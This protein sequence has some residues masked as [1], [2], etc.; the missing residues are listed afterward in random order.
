[1]VCS[2]PNLQVLT[3]S[4]HWNGYI[5][6]LWNMRSNKESVFPKVTPQ[7]S[8]SCWARTHVSASPSPYN[9]LSASSNK[10]VH[11]SFWRG[12][13]VCVHMSVCIYLAAGMQICVSSVLCM[14]MCLCVCI[15]V[16]IYACT[17]FLHVYNL[18]TQLSAYTCLCV[19]TSPCVYTSVSVCLGG[20]VHLRESCT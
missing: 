4:V 7:I 14:H 6:K 2:A 9:F 19:H 5:L 16:L 3:Q 18:C 15:C 20:Y 13:L 1:M 10:H 17:H 11:T 12:V 8:S